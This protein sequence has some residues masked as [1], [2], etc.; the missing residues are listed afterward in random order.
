MSARAFHAI[1]W[2]AMVLIVLMGAALV[3]ALGG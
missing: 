3:A 2:T 1:R